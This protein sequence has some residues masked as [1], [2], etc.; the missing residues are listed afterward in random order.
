MLRE[1]LCA[2]KQGTKAPAQ[3]EEKGKAQAIS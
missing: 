3:T 2:E 1:M